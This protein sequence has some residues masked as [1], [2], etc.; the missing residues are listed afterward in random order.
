MSIT[1]RRVGD[2]TIEL[3]STFPADVEEGLR[4]LRAFTATR[5]S[6]L[7]PEAFERAVRILPASHQARLDHIGHGVRHGFSMG[8]L[9]VPT[10]L[11]LAPKHFRHDQQQVI[12]DWVGKAMEAGFAAGPFHP[13]VVE[14]VMG[15]VACVPLT[16]VH[17][18]ATPTK[19]AKDRVCFNASWDPQEAGIQAG[20]RSINKEVENEEWECEWFLLTEVKLLLGRASPSAMALGF[21]LADAYQQVPNSP[22]QRRRFV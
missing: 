11:V 22:G 9:R 1:A 4:V 8:E 19:P 16:V 14:Q 18:S 10:R 17:T 2:T 3:A 15:P 7:K 21:D 13:S 20:I 5:C 12:R 6:S